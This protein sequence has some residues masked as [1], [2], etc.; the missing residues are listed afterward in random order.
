M[1]KWITSHGL[2]IYQVLSG[3]SNSFLVSSNDKF[4]LIDTGRAS[5]WKKL[6]KN[7]DGIL[8]ENQLSCLI[9]TH[10]HFDH[11]ENATKIKEKYNCKVI[12]HECEANYLK[13]GDSPLPK[14]TNILTRFLIN[15]IGKRIQSRY[16]YDPV[17]LDI[18]VDEKFDLNK[19]GF[20]A[21]IIPTPGHS[22]G[23]ISLIIDDELAIVG[24]AMFGVFKWSVY[25]PFADDTQLMIQSWGK[26]LE[27]G[28]VTYLP[29]HG[30]EI[31]VNLL[32]KQ[33]AKNNRN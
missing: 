29:G 14:G 4:F 2:I 30:T 19:F 11:C 13:N 21:Y 18:A 8:G 16:N 15:F 28:C 24:D 9:L 17:H 1:K 22:P 6:S 20:Q 26:L 10:T 5:S 25:P 23:S 3:R 31:S 27:T 12:V 32:K 33:Y 7:L